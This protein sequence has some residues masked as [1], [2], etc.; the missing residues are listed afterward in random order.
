MDQGNQP[1]F[2][3]KIAAMPPFLVIV[4]PR[5]GVRIARGWITPSTAA[6]LEARADLQGALEV[7]MNETP[8]A[9][10]KHLSAGVFHMPESI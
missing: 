6:L 4:H 1:T 3:P 8:Q 5:P 10:K 2:Q 7:Q 9:T